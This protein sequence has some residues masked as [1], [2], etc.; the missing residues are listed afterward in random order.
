MDCDFDF[1]HCRSSDRGRQTHASGTIGRGFVPDSKTAV[2]VAE[3]I[4]TPIYGEKQVISERP[5]AARLDGDVWTVTGH[6]P[7]G[8]DGG[9]AE[10]ELRRSNAAVLSVHHGK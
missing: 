3:A 7:E 4:L 5:F 8:W 1:G 2:A 10:I 9:V 6:L